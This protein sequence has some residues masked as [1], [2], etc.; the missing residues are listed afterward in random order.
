MEDRRSQAAR[1]LE[2]N[3]STLRSRIKKLGI[4]RSEQGIR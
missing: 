2:L 4:R 3:P 1:L